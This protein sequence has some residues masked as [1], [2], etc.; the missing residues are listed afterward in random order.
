MIIDYLP[1]VASAAASTSLTELSNL[2]I[3]MINK[4]IIIICIKSE[5]VIKHSYALNS[6]NINENKY[7]P[8]MRIIFKLT[9]L[10]HPSN[11]PSNQPTHHPTKPTNQPSQLTYQPTNQPTDKPINQ[12]INQS[13]KPTNQSTN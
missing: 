3:H 9:V 7:H 8:F 13:T 2:V 5:V 6:I 4:I 10:L 1:S 12:R 11:H